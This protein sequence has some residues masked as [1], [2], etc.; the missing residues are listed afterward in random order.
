MSTEKEI[1]NKATIVASAEQTA[2]EIGRAHG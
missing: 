2:N 1:K